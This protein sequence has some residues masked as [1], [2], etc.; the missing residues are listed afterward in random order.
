MSGHS[1]HP[2][3]VR[4]RPVKQD[5]MGAL[6]FYL[7]V[8]FVLQCLAAMPQAMHNMQHSHTDKAWVRASGQMQVMPTTTHVLTAAHAHGDV[9][10]QHDV[11]TV[12]MLALEQTGDSDPPVLLLALWG[13][14]ACT[15]D[16]WK[17][18]TGRETFPAA[19]M[20]SFGSWGTA[21]PL[22]PPQRG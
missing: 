22:R 4:L 19:Q 20:V 2:P 16:L 21:P 1:H 9:Y 3:R 17:Q 6:T 18:M 10:H 5:L 12:D 7:L 13:S 15:W 11:N 8:V 14:V